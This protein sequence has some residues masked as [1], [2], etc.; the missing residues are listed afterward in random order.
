MQSFFMGTMKFDQTEQ[1]GM[2]IRVFVG[3]RCQ[4]V[5]FLMLQ[6]NCP[7]FHF[8]TKALSF[9]VSLN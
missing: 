8:I 3:H 7:K 5:Y 4:K 2:L 6:L 9:I 1:M